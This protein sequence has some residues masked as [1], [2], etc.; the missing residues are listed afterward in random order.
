MFLAQITED[1]VSD[2]TSKLNGKFLEK[3]VKKVFSLLKR[4]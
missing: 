3:L 1:E 4:D 2:V